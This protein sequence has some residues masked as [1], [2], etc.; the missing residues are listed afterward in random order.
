ME[1][2]T[3]A[4]NTHTNIYMFTQ[5]TNKTFK[6]VKRSTQQTSGGAYR[7]SYKWLPGSNYY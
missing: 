5:Q 4:R 7:P 1:P 2:A 3:H 6:T